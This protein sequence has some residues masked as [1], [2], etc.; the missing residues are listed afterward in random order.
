M[1]P[2][3]SAPQDTIVAIRRGGAS[4]SITSLT[5]DIYPD[6]QFGTDPKQAGLGLSR[7]RA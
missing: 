4:L 5:P 3:S 1:P 6:M 2:L 7:T